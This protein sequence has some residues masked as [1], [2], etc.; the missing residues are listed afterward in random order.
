[1]FLYEEDSNCLSNRKELHA[2]LNGSIRKSTFCELAAK[3]GIDLSSI[4]DN[5]GKTLERCFLTFKY[6]HEVCDS[7]E[8]VQ[9]ITEEIIV[10]FI[11]HNTAYFE[12]RTVCFM[13]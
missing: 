10:D 2:H 11:N 13:Y 6:I 12:I 9:R 4:A 1:M 3:K 7:L 5:F 8:I